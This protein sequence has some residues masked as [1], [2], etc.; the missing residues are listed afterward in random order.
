MGVVRVI[1]TKMSWDSYRDNLIASGA[2]KQAAVVG[3]EG[4]A[5]TT[6]PGLNITPDEVRTLM[7]GFSNA[8]TLQANGVR[9]GGQKYMFLQSDDNQIQGKQGATGVS[10]AKAGK[11]LVIG[12]YGDGQQPGACRATVE[13]IRDYLVNSGY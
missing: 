9:V 13:K 6:S 1:T 5:W 2:V 8:G 11:C 12:I 10:I 7:A 4:G 3:H